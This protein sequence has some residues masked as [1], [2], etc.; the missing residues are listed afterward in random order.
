MMTVN[1]WF[2]SSKF[3]LFPEIIFHGIF[4]WF[5][6]FLF[7]L[8]C[9]LAK[10]CAYAVLNGIWFYKIFVVIILDPDKIFESRKLSPCAL[11]RYKSKGYTP[12][13]AY[14]RKFLVLSCYQLHEYIDNG[15]CRI[16]FWLRSFLEPQERLI[17]R[18]LFLIQDCCFPHFPTEGFIVDI[19]SFLARFLVTSI[20]SILALF[21]FLLTTYLKKF[22]CFLHCAI[23]ITRILQR[24]LTTDLWIISSFSR[25]LPAYHALHSSNAF[26][27]DVECIK[28]CYESEVSDSVSL[29][30][31]MNGQCEAVYVDNC[32]N[33]HITN[34]K[35]HF[36]KYT[37]FST[38]DFGG[39]V[40]TIDGNTKPA[41]VGTVRW[42]WRDNDGNISTYD[43][44]GCRYY[45]ES[46]V[47]I[48][49]QTQL[50][51][52]LND[53]DFGTKI[54]SGIHTSIFHWDNQRFRRTI[55]HTTSY[56]PKMIINDDHSSMSTFFTVF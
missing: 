11:N 17:I 43:L 7:L 1:Q 14:S 22:V 20:F 16:F 55:K 2:L 6:F 8:I 49:S 13:H 39:L 25:V 19:S 33:C 47:C 56:M 48:L 28:R 5:R 32:A 26:L 35:A 30:N 36:V 18:Y 54:E 42:S 51:L 44:P 38:A 31:F 53:R 50:G 15:Y 52:F 4:Q 10:I 34:T 40:N 23:R 21:E 29:V 24:F 37:P 12:M 3:A 41:G 45:P 27:T 9:F 46:P